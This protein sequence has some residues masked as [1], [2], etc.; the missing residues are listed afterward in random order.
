MSQ[1]RL[2]SN[3]TG[4]LFILFNGKLKIKSQKINACVVQEERKRK[5]T[6]VSIFFVL[7]FVQGTRYESEFC[8]IFR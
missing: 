7:V 5:M 3:Y 1:A 8:F 2:L 4:K 6:Y